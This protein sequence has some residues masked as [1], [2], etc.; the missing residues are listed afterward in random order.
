MELIFNNQISIFK[1]IFYKYLTQKQC[2]K[3]YTSN[4]ILYNIFIDNNKFKSNY[5]T[6]KTNKEL[7]K[8]VDE[9]YHNKKLSI[10]KYGDI[11]YWNTIYITD[12]HKLFEYKSRFNDDI[13]D[14]NTSN[15]IDMKYMFSDCYYFNQDISNW[16][17][18]NVITITGIFINN[19]E[20]NQNLNKWDINNVQEMNNMFTNNR[21]FNKLNCKDWDLSNK[22]EYNKIWM[23]N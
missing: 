22:A 13:S 21:K 18:K 17:I 16:D 8:A 10:I 4:L 6:P 5:F 11:G 19:Y 15:V 20:F 2:I 7:Y 12:M 9:W 14:W 23:F 3:L 1:D